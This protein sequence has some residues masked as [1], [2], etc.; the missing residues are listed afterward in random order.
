MVNRSGMFENGDQM[1]AD[2]VL[3]LYVLSLLEGPVP[4]DVLIEL[5][6]SPGLV[7]YFAVCQCLT[8]LADGGFIVRN[9]DSMGK[10][11]YDITGSGR[12]MLSSLKY[13]I[14]GGLG[15]A[16]ESYISNHKDDIK[17]RTRTDANWT[18]DSKG[19]IFV[20]CFV[21]EGLNAVIDVTLP[22]SGREDAETIIANWK[23]NTSEK[24]IGI[25]EVLLD[26]S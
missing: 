2:S 13:M 22:V 3:V 8:G 12:G 10:S 11:L 15:A 17:K 26:R 23:N 25:L 1:T 21:R 14:S 24:Y 9:L 19:N 16:Y 20:H 6:M 7:N 18:R 5:L 4:E